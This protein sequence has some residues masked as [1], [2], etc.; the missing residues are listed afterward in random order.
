MPRHNKQ[1]EKKE[2]VLVRM[3]VCKEIIMKIMKF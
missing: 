1:K 3:H 2:I